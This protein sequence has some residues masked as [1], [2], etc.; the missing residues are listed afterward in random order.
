M[1]S[2]PRIIL[3]VKPLSQKPGEERKGPEHSGEKGRRV[4]SYNKGSAL[5]WDS[6]LQ[7]L[8]A[9]LSALR[10]RGWCHSA[11][12]VVYEH[13]QADNVLCHPGDI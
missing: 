6:T 1:N 5:L 7:R 10:E 13:H 9:K 4:L 3:R 8:L 2:H 12:A 11:D